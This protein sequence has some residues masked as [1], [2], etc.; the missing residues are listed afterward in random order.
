MLRP[1]STL[2]GAVLALLLLP[3]G[4]GGGGVGAGGFESRQAWWVPKLDSFNP[5]RVVCF[6]AV[7]LPSTL[8]GAVLCSAGG[9][10]SRQVWY[11]QGAKM[12][13]LNPFFR[14][15]FRVF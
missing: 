5:F 12:D 15:F 9:F 11:L 4:G 8:A 1:L 6:A 3:A 14:V 10:D 13:F 2:A 7:L